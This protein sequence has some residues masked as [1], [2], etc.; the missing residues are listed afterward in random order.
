MGN[1]LIFPYHPVVFERGVTQ[2]DRSAWPVGD[3]RCKLVG[4]SGRQIHHS[5]D[6]EVIVSPR[7]AKDNS[8]EPKLSRKASSEIVSARTANR[9]W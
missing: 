2:E 5:V 1:G 4:G 8:I 7:F 9:H 6:R 3:A